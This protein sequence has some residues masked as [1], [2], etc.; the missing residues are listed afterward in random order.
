MVA[1]RCREEWESRISEGSLLS[2]RTR[3]R[4]VCMLTE[5]QTTALA[6][7]NDDYRLWGCW[8]EMT[9][10]KC[11]SHIENNEQAL[12]RARRQALAA[13]IVTFPVQDTK[14][15][16]EVF[17]RPLSCILRTGKLTC[18]QLPSVRS[19]AG[20]SGTPATRSKGSTAGPPNQAVP[21]DDP[22]PSR[23][24]P[25]IAPAI[26]SRFGT[27][28]PNVP[29]ITSTS[30]TSLPNRLASVS[31]FLEVHRP[32]Q[33]KIGCRSISTE[34]MDVFTGGRLRQRLLNAG[35][36]NTGEQIVRAHIRSEPPSDIYVGPSMRN[37]PTEF[38]VWADQE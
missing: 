16:P 33:Q 25:P 11:I 32:R 38:I 14:S 2:R 18:K 10:R 29:S 5:T 26:T 4:D 19:R 8:L 20:V 31:I 3:P 13:G 6:F 24:I 12:R 28:D 7:A 21:E 9:T 15:E 27:S 36:L 17:M 35:A 22:V 34:E 30:H 23:S 37:V 1:R